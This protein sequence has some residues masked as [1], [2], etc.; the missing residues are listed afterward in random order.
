MQYT[1][2]RIPTDETGNGHRIA[3]KADFIRIMRAPTGSNLR[4]RI[5]DPHS[6]DIDH[7]DMS[8]LRDCAPWGETFLHW[9]A[10]SGGEIKVFLGFGCES[11]QLYKETIEVL[12]GAA[13]SDPWLVKDVSDALYAG[14][15][16]ASDTAAPLAEAQDVHEVQVQCKTDS[17]ES[18]YVGNESA[19]P[20]ELIPG[21]AW[22]GRISDLELLYV[23]SAAGTATFG[24]LARG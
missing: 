21:D 1:V 7:N 19:Q 17:P 11:T 22:A 23:W 6:S 15:G 14:D 13:G 16:T 18:L 10:V 12:Q 20:I 24:Y 8:A 4:I 2:H 3:Y 5:G 9:D